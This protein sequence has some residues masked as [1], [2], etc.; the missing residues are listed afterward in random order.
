MYEPEQVLHPI[1]LSTINATLKEFG[2]PKLEYKNNTNNGEWFGKCVRCFI[3]KGDPGDDRF[4]AWPNDP[5]RPVD[6]YKGSLPCFH[7]RQCARSNGNVWTGDLVQFY[8]DVYNVDFVTAR[9]ALGLP[10]KKP[11]LYTKLA[12]S[13][14]RRKPPLP[15]GEVWQQA[16]WE[17]L[18]TWQESLQAHD[19]AL[20]YLLDRG[21]TQ[22]NIAR[23]KFAYTGDDD[24]Y[25]AGELLGLPDK[26]VRI[27]SG[28]VIPEFHVNVITGEQEVWNVIIRRDDYA[29]EQEY[30][31]FKR[32][33][34]YH[35]LK[36]GQSGLF[37]DYLLSRKKPCFLVEGQLDAYSLLQEAGD[38][39]TPVATCGKLGARSLYYITKLNLIPEFVVIVK[40]VDGEG[41]TSLADF[42]MDELD[43]AL[44]VAPPAHDI[45]CMLQ[46]R[47]GW[48]REWVLEILLKC[49][50][51]GLQ[52]KNF[53]GSILTGFA[54]KN[55]QISIVEPNKTTVEERH[56]VTDEVK[57]P[58]QIEEQKAQPLKSALGSKIFE[59]GI[60]TPL[61][62]KTH[63]ISTVAPNTTVLQ[64]LWRPCN[65][66]ESEGVHQDLDGVFWCVEHYPADPGILI[67]TL[68][69]L[70]EWVELHRF[71][72]NDRRLMAR[73]MDLETTGLNPQKHKIISLAMETEHGNLLIDMRRF[74]EKPQ[75]ERELW[76]A[77]IRELFVDNVTWIGHNI[78]FD[79]NFIAVHLGIKGIKYVY[80]SQIVETI[81]TAGRQ[82]RTNMKAAANRYG[83]HV[84]KDERDWF[85]DLD[86]RKD[87]WRNTFPKEQRWYMV[88]DIIVPK[89]LM[90]K[91]KA[92]IEEQKLSEVVA[93]EHAALPALSAMEV[94]GV[95][96]NK[97][98]WA[99]IIR[100]AEIEQRKLETEIQR[101]LSEAI[102]EKQQYVQTSLFDGEVASVV[103]L[104]SPI[105]VKQALK[106]LGIDVPSVKREELEKV[107]GEH[108]IIATMIEWKRL[109]KLITSFGAPLLGFIQ[110]DERIHANF[111]QI[112]A[113]TGRMSCREPNLQQI[114]KADEDSED[115]YD[116]RSCFVAPQGKVLL[117]ADFPN[118]ELRILANHA[119]DD[120]MLAAFE[121]D[122]DKADLHSYTARKMFN[123]PDNVNPK[124]HFIH[125]VQARHAAKQI[126]FGLM[127]GMGPRRLAQKVGCDVDTAKQLIEVYF[128]AYNKVAAY[129]RFS[130]AKGIQQRYAVT[131]SGRRRHFD[132][133]EFTDPAIRAQVERWSKNHPIQGLNADITKVAL[134]LLYERLPE[135]CATV[136]VVHDEIV[137]EA[138]EALQEEAKHILAMCM[139]EACKRY[140]KVVRIPSQKVVIDKR[141][142]KD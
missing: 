92:I 135:G 71:S 59:G 45:N 133:L 68:D 75:E 63:Q 27:P 38:L 112:G 76:K 87:D 99:Q 131:A 69:A 86:R 43:D 142:S 62:E 2:L 3:E 102:M 11:V 88:Q 53:E 65:V 60:K 137:V 130:A 109:E 89:L 129:L 56:V 58:D 110:G 132:H 24:R 120:V 10:P 72:A 36:G 64:S 116:I 122:D 85:I 49:S 140:L 97:S 51:L 6:G 17:L 100:R 41:K 98:A 70:Q 39:I 33:E 78:K 73:C 31:L 125:G 121:D 83:I 118:I 8:R 95:C 79:L 91:Q 40:D 117:T 37:L 128:Q 84:S 103:N 9:Q 136:L 42:W 134:A 18:A 80:D 67:D 94:H 25:I 61:E 26:Q 114:P 28:I 32:R 7:C 139:E 1:I 23:W 19:G 29:I 106:K 107:E 20:G 5:S 127:F 119:K 93:L 54:P 21:F 57:V 50:K 30:Q 47:P 22:D 15:P 104:A 81:I 55:P 138:P 90:R 113:V 74:Y 108:P 52:S 82:L 48:V 44:C 141:W 12:P 16:V 111:F 123:L 14:D 126:N 105:Q 96:I 46:E 77:A 101:V 66:C 34:K 124:Q 13:L 115:P 4:V 35:N